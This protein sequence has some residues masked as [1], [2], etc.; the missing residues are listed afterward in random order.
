MRLRQ[1]ALVARNLEATVSDLRAV[2]DLE[3]GFRDPGVGVFGLRNAVLPVGDC[4]LE[5]V[6]PVRADASAARF[7]ERRGGDGG[8]MVIVQV[9]DLA[10]ARLRMERE[11]V[12]I[13]FEHA[14][15]AGHTATIHLHPRDVGGAILSFDESNPPESWDWAGPDW[16]RHVR[17]DVATALGGATLESDD[18]AGLAARWGALL[19]R[20]ASALGGGVFA[21]ALD[22]ATLRFVPAHGRGDAFVGVDLLEAS[23]GARQGALAAARRRGLRV[24]GDAAWIAGAAIHLVDAPTP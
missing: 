22:G 8:Y 11:K 12:R 19:D 7:L 2:L 17:R 14:H 20:P 9:E 16:Q 6:S 15:P 13:V 4:F 1:V 10:A 24:E 5:V 21:I 18:P 23:R 3:I